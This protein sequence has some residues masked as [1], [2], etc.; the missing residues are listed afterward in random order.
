M[1]DIV[2]E[3]R[4]EL[5]SNIFISISYK[6]SWQLSVNERTL[7]SLIRETLPFPRENYASLFLKVNDATVE[8]NTAY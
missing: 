3:K 2:P 1:R 4:H 6:K 5:K 8:W 7:P